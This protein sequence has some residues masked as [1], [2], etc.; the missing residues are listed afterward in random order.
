MNYV[1]LHL[2]DW[3]KAVAHLTPVEEGVYLRLLRRYYADEAP[4]PVDVAACQRLAAART[5]DE[6]EAVVVV[7]AEFFIAEA[8][9]HHNKRADEEIAKY[10]EG[11]PEREA[12][13]ANERERQRRAREERRR[14]FDELRERGVVPA[15]DAPTSELRRLL[16]QPVTRDITRTDDVRPCD[17]TATHTP[18]PNTHK[19]EQ[20]Q[21]HERVP[22]SAD[23]FAEFWAAYP[24]KK[25]KKNAEAAWRRKG[26]DPQADAILADV[27]RRKREDREW[28]SGYSPHGST[29]VNAEGWLDGLPPVQIDMPAGRPE[30]VRTAPPVLEGATAIR[31]Q[32]GIPTIALSPEERQQRVAAARAAIRGV[33]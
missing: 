2:G 31:G 1:E 11:E 12:K 32:L 8:D 22:R 21:K 25:G 18:I 26:L 30:P 28:I 19:K 29:Y 24:N 23:R 4:L 10:H 17:V 33:P 14:L 9:G 3:A 20:E 7:L 5:P 16:S 15:Y 6:R 13:R 27:E